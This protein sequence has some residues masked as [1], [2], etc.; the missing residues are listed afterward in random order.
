MPKE[1]TWGPVSCQI[2]LAEQGDLPLTPLK[3][4]IGH[5]FLQIQGKRVSRKDAKS[6]KYAERVKE[7]FYHGV[8]QR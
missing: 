8:T 6:A 5:I 4:F 3:Y 1:F 2:T 7:E